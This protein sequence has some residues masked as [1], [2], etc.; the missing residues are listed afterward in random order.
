[1]NQKEA[2]KCVWERMA[3]T[4]DSDGTVNTDWVFDESDKVLDHDRLVLACEQ[5]AEIIRRKFLKSTVK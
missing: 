1:M 4:A 3:C 5:V 2:R